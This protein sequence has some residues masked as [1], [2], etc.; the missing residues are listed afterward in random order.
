LIFAAAVNKQ[1]Q[2]LEQLRAKVREAPDAAEI[3]ANYTK[4]LASSAEAV[5][6][7]LKTRVSAADALSLLNRRLPAGTWLT[8]VSYNAETGCVV[9]G[10]SKTPDGPQLAHLA[11]LGEDKFDTVSFDY[12]TQDIVGDTPVWGFQ[13]TCRLQAPNRNQTRRGAGARR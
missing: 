13:I 9:R 7:A 10:M 11:I 6:T 12:R 2:E 4:G 5:E 1:Q 8:D 3:P